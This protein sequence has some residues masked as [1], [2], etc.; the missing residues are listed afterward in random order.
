MKTK[1]D[2][3]YKVIGTLV[4]FLLSIVLGIFIP[5]AIGPEGYGEYNYILSTGNFLLQFFIMSVNTAYIYMHTRNKYDERDLNTLYLVYI[6]IVFLMLIFV[7][8]LTISTEYLYNT[9]WNS[10]SK[11]QYIILGFLL[12]SFIFLQQRL[13]EYSDMIGEAKFSE[14]MKNM[15][16]LI[17][18]LVVLILILS[19]NISIYSLLIVTILSHIIYL[20]C[21]TIN[22]KIPIAVID[23]N[24]SKIY[25]GICNEIYLYVKPLIIFS[26]IGALYLYIG[27]YSLQYTSSLHEFGIY[28]AAL[29]LA[30]IPIQFISAMIAIYMKKLIVSHNSDDGYINRFYKE[31]IIRIYVIHAVFSYYILFNA[32]SIIELLL[33]VDYEGAVDVIRILSIFSLIHTYGILGGNVYLSTNRNKEYAWIN[34]LFLCLGIIFCFFVIQFH[35]FSALSFA[36]FTTSIFLSRVLLQTYMNLKY[37][38]IPMLIYFFKFVVVN[39]VLLVIIIP[40]SYLHISI[41]F[42]PILIAI[43]LIVINIFT[44]DTLKFNALYKGFR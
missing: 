9:F 6:S 31:D 29:N 20:I 24:K 26:I 5:R 17:L 4:S 3:F 8:Y 23:R 30:N 39:F 2:L 15:T 44:N 42:K 36:V 11:Y 19:K 21:I 13:S 35:Y 16:K 32:S 28:M 43:L 18:V 1:N 40:I 34:G 33:G 37:L 41:F 38:K 22:V 25:V 10:I 7:V 12:S 14:K 27:R